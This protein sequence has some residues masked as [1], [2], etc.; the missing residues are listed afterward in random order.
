M[1]KDHFLLALV[2]IMILTAIILRIT[3]KKEELNEDIIVEEEKVEELNI[4]YTKPETE[5]I[6]IIQPLKNELVTSPLMVKGMIPANWLLETNYYVV[7]IDNENNSIIDVSRLETEQD[8][9]TMEAVPFFSILE[10]SSL[11][12]Q[13]TISIREME[14]NSLVYVDEAE[15]I[16]INYY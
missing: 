13:G 3:E 14:N 1:K 7:L 10:F 4:D 6:K 2:A 9:D 15:E 16:L 8:W 11:S 12:G 5:P